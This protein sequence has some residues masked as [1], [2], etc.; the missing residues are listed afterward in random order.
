[1]VIIALIMMMIL[2]I[3]FTKSTVVGVLGRYSVAVPDPAV[4]DSSINHARVLILFLD[5]EEDIALVPDL[6]HLL[7]TQNAVQVRSTETN[8]INEFLSHIKQP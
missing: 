8:S 1:M 4:V 3:F 2:C 7:A 6:Y 5:I